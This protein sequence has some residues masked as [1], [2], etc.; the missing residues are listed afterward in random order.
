VGKAYFIYRVLH[1]DSLYWQAPLPAEGG[2]GRELGGLSLS[3]PLAGRV[4]VD[5]AGAEAI[6]DSLAKLHKSLVISY[7]Y[8]Q[9]D[10]GSL[11]GVGGSARV[12]R[13]RLKQ[14]TVAA[15]VRRR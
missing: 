3:S 13:A 9:L 4:E 8:L 12:Y 15:K 6:N 14:E 11:L 1:E 10:K 5:G 7:G 2:G